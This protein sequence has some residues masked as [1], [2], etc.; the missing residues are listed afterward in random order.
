MFT[1]TL[2]YTVTPTPKHRHTHLYDPPELGAFFAYLGL[3]ALHYP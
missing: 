3:S 2:E 1:M